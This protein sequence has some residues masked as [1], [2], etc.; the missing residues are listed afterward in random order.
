MGA[1]MGIG[2]VQE[3]ISRLTKTRITK[4]NTSVNK[5]VVE[6]EMYFPFGQ[7]IYVDA[8]HDAT[9]A[10][11]KGHDNTIHRPSAEH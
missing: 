6:S 7:P 1:A 3:L 11:S 8:T 9:I 10:S 2:W 5:T 4:F